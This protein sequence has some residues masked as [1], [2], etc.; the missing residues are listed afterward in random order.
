[1]LVCAAVLAVC[2]LGIPANAAPVLPGLFSD[3]MVL[4]QGRAV[5]VWGWADPG[6]RISVTLGQ[7]TRTAIAGAD[8]HWKLLLPAMHAGGP[9]TLTIAGKRTV[10]IKDVMIGEVWVLSGQSNMAFALSGA[11]GAAD[12]IATANHPHVRLFTVPRV[13]ATLP[14]R[15]ARASWQICT[16]ETAREFSAVAY[17]FG[18]E[19]HRELGVPIGLIHSSW[20]GTA[21]EEWTDS[22]SLRTDAELASLL[23]MWDA[24]NAEAKRLARGPVEFALEFDDFE[25]IPK[26]NAAPAVVFSNF[27]DG[28]A[29]NALHGYW[30]YD[31]RFAPHSAF[32][33]TQAGHSA[34]AYVARVAGQLAAGDSSLLRA[35]FSPDGTAVDLSAYAGI[36]F[37]YSGRGNFRVHSIQ[38]TI[39]DWDNY[40][41]PAFTAADQ[42]QS[43]VIWFKDL[44]QAGW[45][46]ILAF[47]PAALS[48][49]MIEVLPSVRNEMRPPSS[50]Y[51]GM[52][53]PL[54]PYAIRGVAWYQG[55]GNALRADQYRK[56]LPAMITGWRRAWGQ[57][58]FPFLIVQ[59]PN[60]G[61]RATA[62]EENAWAELREA[63]LQTLRLAGTGLAITID[64]GEGDDIH[65][66]NKADVGKRLALWALGTSYGRNI[67][68]SGPMYDS[69]AT[70]GDRVRVRFR[71]IGGGLTTRD[72]TPV[73]GFALAGGDRVFHWADAVIDGDSVVVSSSVVAAPVAVRYAWA[74]NPE[75]N[76][77]NKEG[78]PASPFRTDQW[79]GVAR[80]GSSAR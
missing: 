10:A 45:G 42:W 27:D 77:Q 12:E 35:S 25:L 50:L 31:W 52:I 36:R 73:K 37:R 46:K 44:K 54:F 76:L 78:L 21:A 49:L 7:N 74:G 11:T 80:T 58:D 63:Q 17:F 39:T 6:E 8:R 69:M 79:P 61:P 53:A 66:H 43:A 22:A 67:T 48:G 19:L 26:D 14:L 75:C 9:F 38:P 28:A 56:L 34:G 13:R 18:K 51:N 4:Q 2:C 59:L 68:Y 29:R 23:K 30:T 47:T 16:P 24:A 55:E 72:G 1:M 60:Y 70:E 15:D 32:E 71:H 64:V 65:P 62:P 3:H 5:P 33:L 20:P 57:G 41:T 40:A